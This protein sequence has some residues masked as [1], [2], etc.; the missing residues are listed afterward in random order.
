[1][2]GDLQMKVYGKNVEKLSPNMQKLFF[3]HGS[4]T[5]KH[6]WQQHE[7]FIVFCSTVLVSCRLKLYIHMHLFIGL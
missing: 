7:L 4:N 2:I 3:L 6:T 5:K 1:M